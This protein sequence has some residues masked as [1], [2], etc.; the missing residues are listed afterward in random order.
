LTRE[1]PRGPD[2]PARKIENLVAL[3][4]EPRGQ[5]S[6][7]GAERSGSDQAKHS[8]FLTRSLKKWP[9]LALY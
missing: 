2:S 8:I 5:V 3:E 4:E 7:F 1:E 9:D 6:T